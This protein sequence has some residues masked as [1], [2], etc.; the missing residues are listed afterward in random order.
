MGP[1][2]PGPVFGMGDELS[3]HRI[4]VDVIQ[5]L[6]KFLLA[7]DVEIIETSVPEVLVRSRVFGR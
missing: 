6:V 1:T 4:G 3:H 7:P 2:A 5:L